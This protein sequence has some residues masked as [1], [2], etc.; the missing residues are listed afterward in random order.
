MLSLY[1]AGTLRLDEL[2]TARYRL[3]DVNQGYADL[4][5]GKNIRG[6]I[7]HSHD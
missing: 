7:V 2:I 4:H 1:E 3:E 6:I 5:A